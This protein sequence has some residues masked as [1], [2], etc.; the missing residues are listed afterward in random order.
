MKSDAAE[1]ACKIMVIGVGGAGNNA[2]NRMV[3]VGIRGVE[4]MAVNTDLKDLRSCKAPNYVQIGQKLTKGLGAGADPERGEK[5]AEETIDEIK[6]RIEGYD[7]VFITC[8]MGGGTGTGAAPVIARAAKEMGILTTA[9]VTKPFSFESRG[10]MKKAEMGIARLAES[11]DTYTV[12]PN[13]KLRALDPKLPFEESFKK[14]DEVLQQS[15]QGITDLITGEALMNVDF[16]DVRTTMHDKGV[17]HIG[18]GS[19]KGESRAM[20]AVKKAVE[21]PLLDTKLDGAKNLIYNITGCVTNED[22]YSISDFLNNLIDDEAEVIFG[23]DNSGDAGDD[24]ISV[25]V[26]ATGLL[27]VGQQQQ[28]QEKPKAPNLFAGA[29]MA[30]GLNFGGAGL[31]GSGLG[32]AG[33]GAAGITGAGGVSTLGGMRPVAPQTDNVQVLGTGGTASLGGQGFNQ[34]AQQMSR[35]VSNST[36]SLDTPSIGRVEPKSINIPDFLKRH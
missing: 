25:T 1:Y 35:P 36:V 28:Q 3:D 24:T 12:I 4:L 29:G 18:M 11:V 33:F 14:A 23:T 15:V 26:I 30:G 7:M 27:E 22:V 8:G 31:S 16:A 13:D 9:I 2:L 6:S 20:D 17:A 19:G 32:G 5:A 10:R 21:N 34:G